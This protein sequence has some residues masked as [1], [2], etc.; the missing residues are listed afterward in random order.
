M[1]LSSWL[2]RRPIL[3][4]LHWMYQ[5]RRMLSHFGRCFAISQILATFSQ[6]KHFFHNKS[7]LRLLWQKILGRWFAYWKI[8]TVVFLQI[9]LFKINEDVIQ[10]DS[11][12]WFLLKSA[13]SSEDPDQTGFHTDKMMLWYLQNS[14]GLYSYTTWC[15]FTWQFSFRIMKPLL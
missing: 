2:P 11:L 15:I 3:K 7:I 12:N 5:T 10:S 8:S 1:Y 6:L 9:W 4:M 14:G 13:F